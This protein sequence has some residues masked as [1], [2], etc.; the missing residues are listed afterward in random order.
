METSSERR[1]GEAGGF[2]VWGTD[3]GD[4]RT[5]QMER[6]GVFWRERW[7]RRGV[8]KDGSCSSFICRQCFIWRC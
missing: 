4:V 6:C 2:L 8:G 5:A 1:F 7:Q 3:A